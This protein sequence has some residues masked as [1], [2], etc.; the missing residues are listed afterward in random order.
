MKRQKAKT[1]L[2]GTL[3]LA[4]I[5]C[6]PAAFAG[7]EEKPSI[8]NN[9]L[10]NRVEYKSMQKTMDRIEKDQARIEFYKAEYKANKE[11][12]E[13][14]KAHMSKKEWRKA[15]ADLKRDKKYLK[16][17]KRDLKKDQ[18]VAI[19]E[20][21][22]KEFYAKVEL[23]RAKRELRRD[24]RK[25]NISELDKDVAEVKRLEKQ[26]EKREAIATNLEEDTD[27]FFRVFRRRD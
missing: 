27:E 4:G 10:K 22:H 12:G 21:E 19:Y 18:R 2:L 14:I 23:W 24:L 11:A 7:E 17:D 13:T 8:E 5:A 20:A 26:V 1:V 25:G 9:Q 15:K 3:L 6:S 16:I